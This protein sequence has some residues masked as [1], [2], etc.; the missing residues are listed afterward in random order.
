[1]TLTQPPSSDVDRTADRRTAREV[2]VFLAV[3]AALTAAGTGVA[4]S[5]GVDVRQIEDASALGQS[6]MYAQAAFPLLGAVTARLVVHRSLR[7]PGWGVRRVSWA[8]LGL[9]WAVGVAMVL[10]GASIVWGTGLG[11]FDRSAAGGS[12]LL[13]LTV[14]VVPYA[15]LALAEDLGWRGLMV[16]RLAEVA[17]PGTV[18][19]GSGLAWSAF[20]WPL[21]ALLGGTPDGVAVWFALMM[22]T[23]GT[24]ALGA[25][26]A[27]MQLRWG[28]WPGVVLHAAVNATA[29]H[30]VDP[31]TVEQGRT[32]WF[33]TE[34]GL[35][36][37]L[38][39]L[40]AAWLWM[41]RF[42]LRRTAGGAT[43]VG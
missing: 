2:G 42:P 3:T 43:A 7:R 26:L 15:V 40:V 11:G 9:A 1:M 5:E 34:T 25:V 39:A 32:T 36:T 27:S 31:L 22:F 8:R 13:G 6:V 29:Y 17:S 41:R 33:S 37:A 19:L 38:V 21:I 14:L 24:T 35:V 30:V 12:T 23:V 20:H 18:V 16:T 28:I 10:A 4:L